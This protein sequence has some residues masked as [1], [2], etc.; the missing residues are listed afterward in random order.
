MKVAKLVT[1]ILTTRVIV[2]QGTSDEEVTNQ[3]KLNLIAKIKN[4]EAYENLE[5]VENDTECPYNIKTDKTP[6]GY[7]Q[8]EN[9]LLSKAKGL[10]SFDTD[11]ELLTMIKNIINHEETLDL[12]DYVD[13]VYVWD[14]YEFEFTVE[15]FLE[16]IKYTGNEFKN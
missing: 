15:E 11:E 10:L 12:V 13:D 14:K 4:N 6:T 8:K 5:S 9:I 2:E 16:E 3:A 7:T 1:V